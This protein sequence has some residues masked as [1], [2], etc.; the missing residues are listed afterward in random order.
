M[1]RK[2]GQCSFCYYYGDSYCCE[3]NGLFKH[4][5]GWVGVEI[6]NHPLAALAHRGMEH[7]WWAG[8]VLAESVL[9]VCLLLLQMVF[10]NE[11]FGE[12]LEVYLTSAWYRLST[13][14]SE[15]EARYLGGREA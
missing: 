11:W 8:A 13:E 2:R 15:A 6:E 1:M 4:I 10:C 7:Q 14:S 9:G 12:S 5:G 3:E